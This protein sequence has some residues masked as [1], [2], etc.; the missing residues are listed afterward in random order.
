MSKRNVEI[1][2]NEVK[3]Y[4]DKKECLRNLVEELPVIDEL[5]DEN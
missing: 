3:L 2:K 5:P 1:L 4:N